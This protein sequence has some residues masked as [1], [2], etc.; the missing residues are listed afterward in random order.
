[1]RDIVDE[2][3]ALAERVRKLE[4]GVDQPDAAGGAAPSYGD[5][6][7]VEGTD[8]LDP[9]DWVQMQGTWINYDDSYKLRVRKNLAAGQ[10]EFDGSIYNATASPT[11]TVFVLPAG[12][13]DPWHGDRHFT[14]PSWN[15]TDGVWATTYMHVRD[16]G[17]VRW[18]DGPVQRIDLS[19]IRIPITLTGAVGGGGWEGSGV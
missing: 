15:D 9:V 2:V 11:A 18:L 12:Y 13:T 4:T 17:Y 14:C 1:M 7:V 3:S 8:F 5:W 16:D 6:K 19:V 10:I